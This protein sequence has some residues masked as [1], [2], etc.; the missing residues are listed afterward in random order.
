LNSPDPVKVIRRAPGRSGQS[1]TTVYR[2]STAL[3]PRFI[4][5]LV[6]FENLT[7]A[8]LPFPQAP[9][10]AMVSITL[11]VTLPALALA[12]DPGI[13]WA[14]ITLTLVLLPVND[15]MQNSISAEPPAPIEYVNV[16]ELK[17][18]RKVVEELLFMMA[19]PSFVI[20]P[21]TRKAPSMPTFVVNKPFP[22]TRSR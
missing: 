15:V 4:V 14:T 13:N 17:P 6:V 20:F 2:Y 19:L 16:P 3:D 11:I 9:P 21:S 8:E 5:V 10:L 18:L 7:I 12:P 22:S 1:V